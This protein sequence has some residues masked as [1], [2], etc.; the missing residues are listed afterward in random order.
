MAKLIEELKAAVS[1]KTKKPLAAK[2][3]AN[4]YGAVRTMMRSARLAE[5]VDSDPCD[6]PR[7]ILPRKIGKSR[8]PYTGAEVVALTGPGV[9]PLHRMFNA[10]AFYTG[11]REGEICA[12]RWSDYDSEAGALAVS[13]QYDDQPLKTDDE[14]GE[15]PR[16]VPVHENLAAALEW[17]AADGFRAVF[18]R[19]PMPD[20]RIVPHPDGSTHTRGTAYYYWRQS[21][22]AAGVA[23][24]SLHSTRHTFITLARRGGARKDVIERVTHN[25]RGDIVDRYTHFDW[26][27]LV[28][29]VACLRVDAGVDESSGG[30]TAVFPSPVSSPGGATVGD[31]NDGESPSEPGVDDPPVSRA[32]EGAAADRAAR[33][34]HPWPYGPAREFRVDAGR[35]SRV[36]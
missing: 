13:S 28:A 11:M 32:G 7:G 21:C 3:V 33:Q 25:A 17:W 20:D 29:A 18:G 24:R 36:A 16:I 15:H 12:R 1:E 8:A 23:N 9:P 27:P 14:H 4:T 26:S 35:V 30:P 2:T 34:Q 10:L 31:G 6:L 5:L 19:D 22:A